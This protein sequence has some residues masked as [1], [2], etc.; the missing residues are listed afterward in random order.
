MTYSTDDMQD[1]LYQHI[2]LAS[3]MQVNIDSYD[4]LHLVLSAPLACNSNDKGSA[5]AGSIS[6]LATMSGWIALMLWTKDH[7][8]GEFLVAVAHADIHYKKP[9]LTDFTA[10]ATLPHGDAL[11]QLHKTLLH[12]G[13]GR[14]QLHIEV[15]DGHGVAVTQVAEY[16]VW[17]VKELD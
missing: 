11:A 6:S 13:R 8:E 1:F 4:G 12:K 10:R 3:A 9:I 17:R 7:Y 14:A 2:P 16:A 5:F 15:C